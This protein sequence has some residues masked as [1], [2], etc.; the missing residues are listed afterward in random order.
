MAFWVSRGLGRP[1]TCCTLQG[2]VKPSRPGDTQ[3]RPGSPVTPHGCQDQPQLPHL[4]ALLSC[5]PPELCHCPALPSIALVQCA[6]KGCGPLASSRLLTEPGFLGSKATPSTPHG[7]SVPLVHAHGIQ[8]R[9][10][11]GQCWTVPLA[12]PPE[13]T[14]PLQVTVRPALWGRIH[15]A[16]L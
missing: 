2:Y 10:A 8:D 16:G 12:G 15:P 7:S 1:P 3:H 6:C 14:P 13:A 5:E 11:A 9:C 4:N